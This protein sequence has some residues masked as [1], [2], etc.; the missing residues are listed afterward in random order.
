[1]SANG[2]TRAFLPRCQQRA[3]PETPRLSAS[4]E[5]IQEDLLRRLRSR[6]CAP[7]K[8]RVRYEKKVI[9]SAV[10][11]RRHINSQSALRRDRGL[12]AARTPAESR[13]NYSVDCEELL[14]AQASCNSWS[15]P[16]LQLFSSGKAENESETRQP[17]RIFFSYRFQ[18]ACIQ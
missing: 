2:S 16:P 1:V 18:S 14:I 6:A 9:N 11:A 10:S 7:A 13:G 5:K 4:P 17:R 3:L 12:K 15:F 8:Q